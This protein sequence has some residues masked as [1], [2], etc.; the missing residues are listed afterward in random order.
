MTE[1]RLSRIEKKLDQLAEAIG[2]VVRI[3]ERLIAVNKRIDLHETRINGHSKT[4]DDVRERQIKADSVSGWYTAGFWA[5]AGG[6]I[7][8]AVYMFTH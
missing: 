2:I 5:V 4:I 3:E 1:D 7:S 6:V 8:V